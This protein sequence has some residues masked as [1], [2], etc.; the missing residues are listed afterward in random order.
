MFLAS[1]GRNLRC[2]YEA[3]HRSLVRMFANH[4]RSGIAMQ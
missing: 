3:S 1:L 4:L 2:V